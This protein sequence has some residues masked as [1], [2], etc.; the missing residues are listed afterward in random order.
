VLLLTLFYFLQ[1]L[2]QRHFGLSLQSGLSETSFDFWIW[3]TLF[4]V[5]SLVLKPFFVGI[6]IW[7]FLRYPVSIT[8][9]DFAVRENVRALGSIL[10]YGLLFI[11]PG[12][13][14]YLELFWLPWVV[15]LSS[16]YKD[17]QLDAFCAS[18]K[19]F[20]KHS[21]GTI[22]LVILTDVLIAL[23]IEGFLGVDSFSSTIYLDTAIY[24]LALGTV[25]V[26]VGYL[27]YRYFQ[28]IQYV[29]QAET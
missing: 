8:D 10:T 1:S 11:L 19:L 12:I 18:R 13:W 6:W 22:G 24:S 21:F 20:R 5:M 26:L 25:A 16:K 3:L 9:F 23:L 29:I 28:K 4:V 7:A 27:S 14:R 17:G 2:A 15:Y